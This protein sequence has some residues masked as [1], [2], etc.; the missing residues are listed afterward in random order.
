VATVS[1]T[2]TAVNDKPVVTNLQGA[3][4]ANEGETKAYTFTITDNDSSNF[5]FASGSPTCGAPKGEVVSGSAQ[6]NGNNGSFECKFLD[7]GVPPTQVSVSAKVT[8]DSQA[9]SDAAT[10][11]VAVSNVA[12]K[13]D[14]LTGPAQVLTNQ[15]VTFTGAHSDPAGLLD[16]PFT[17]QWSGGTSTDTDKNNSY[18]TKFSACG[19]QNVKATVTDKDTGTSAEATLSTPVQAYNGNFLPP[20]QTGKDNLVQKGQVVP[21]KITVAGCDGLNLAGLSPYIQLFSGDPTTAIN[22][23]DYVVPTASVSSADTGQNM[24]PVADGYI[25]NLRVPSDSKA[26]VGAKYYIRVSPFGVASGQHMMISIQ[27][28]K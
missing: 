27:I 6:I 23:A 26:T 16:N 21:V 22:E 20:L 14:S 5:T 11:N 10:K 3:D 2:V 13:I 9:S 12:P 24:R 15:P 17:W 1:I 18:V 4:T 25:Y 19:P 28:R 7:G 8:D